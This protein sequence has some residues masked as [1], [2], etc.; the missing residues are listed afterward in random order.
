MALR[1][2]GFIKWQKLCALLLAA[3][4]L[5]PASALT[6]LAAQEE[7]GDPSPIIYVIGQTPLYV[8]GLW[9]VLHPGRS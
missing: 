2:I 4:L 6:A 1:S 9:V 8:P 5:V 3:L 7:S